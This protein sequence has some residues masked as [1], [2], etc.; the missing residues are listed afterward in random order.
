ML[1]RYVLG[2][3]QIRSGLNIN[4]M[5]LWYVSME[6]FKAPGWLYGVAFG[7]YA[8]YLVNF[9]AEFWTTKSVTFEAIIKGE[10]K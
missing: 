5:L 10:M 2:K 4:T 3:N 9:I 8:L 1:Q 7:L 6:F